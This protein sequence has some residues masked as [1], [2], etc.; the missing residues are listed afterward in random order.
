MKG[1]ILT[2][3]GTKKAEI[4]LPACF[5]APVRE[6]LIKRAFEVEAASRQPYGTFPQAGK[7]TVI[8]TRHRRRKWKTLYGYGISRAPRKIMTRRGTRFYWVGAFAPGTKGGR[9]AHP[10][11]AEKVWTKRMPQKEKAKALNAA[12]AATAS[13]EILKKSYAGLEKLS[14]PLIVEEKI[15][16][17]KKARELLSVL[18]KFLPENF[19]ERKRQK[20]KPL[21][22][23]KKDFALARSLGF[24]VCTVNALKISQLAPGGIPGRLTIYTESAI[25]ELGKR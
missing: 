2:I 8:T 7:G 23:T 3:E 15:T 13:V 24:D 22:V 19:F 18:K 12:I 21:I 17:I 9:A 14:L 4:E 11:K 1:Q 10:P 25:K 20:K 5:S 6:D 16:E